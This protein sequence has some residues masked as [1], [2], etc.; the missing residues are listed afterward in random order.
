MFGGCCEEEEGV[1]V[2]VA[3]D[4]F[5]G[6]LPLFVVGVEVV[7]GGP[8]KVWGGGEKKSGCGGGG[9]SGGTTNGG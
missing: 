1:D 2:D 6:D 9:G 5:L 8:L 7:A 3:V 4:V